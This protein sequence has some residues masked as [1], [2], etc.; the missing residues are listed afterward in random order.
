M[1]RNAMRLQSV[2]RDRFGLV[3]RSEHREM[4]IY[5]LVTAKGGAK[6]TLHTSGDASPSLSSN[7][8]QITGT[9]VTVWMLAQQLSQLLGRPVHDETN[10]EGQFDFKV[11]PEPDGPMSES[12]FTALPDQLGLKLESAKGPVQVYVVEKLEQPTEN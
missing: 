4:S 7:G 1:D 11:S 8:R 2:L 3:L 10:L 5:R 6:L 12:L 9:N